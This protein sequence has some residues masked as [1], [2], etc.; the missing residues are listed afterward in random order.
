M[1]RAVIVI[2]EYFILS[3]PGKT[4]GHIF[5][6]AASSGGSGGE[7]NLSKMFLRLAENC[8]SVLCCRTTPSQKAKV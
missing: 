5:S 8:L 6:S 4:L 1:H 3:F 7:R 2:Y